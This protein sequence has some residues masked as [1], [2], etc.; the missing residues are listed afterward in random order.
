MW[1]EGEEEEDKGEGEGTAEDIRWGEGVE[2]YTSREG[3]GV[4]NTASRTVEGESWVGL[5]WLPW[6]T[7]HQ[8]VC[9][10]KLDPHQNSSQG[11]RQHCEWAEQMPIRACLSLCQAEHSSVHPPPQ[12]Y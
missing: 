3:E 6:D 10:T 1:L 7:L 9:R 8:G 5:S 2:R 12:S 4:G 11:R